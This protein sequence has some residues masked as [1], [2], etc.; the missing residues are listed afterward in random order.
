[1]DYDLMLSEFHSIY[2]LAAAVWPMHVKLSNVDV[3]Y[4]FELGI[5]PPLF[6]T[7]TRCRNQTLRCQAI[8]LIFTEFYREN[9]WDSFGIGH[10]ARWI[11]SMEEVEKKMQAESGVMKIERLL[12]GIPRYTFNN[13]GLHKSFEV[14]HRRAT[15]DGEAAKSIPEARR[16]KITVKYLIY[17][18][19]SWSMRKVYRK[20]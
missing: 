17:V 15:A 3:S 5:L 2:T 20:H 18:G 8:N 9:S 6:L 13:D 10:I 12:A 7:A 16:V 1:M 19:H 11:M 4:N 14:R